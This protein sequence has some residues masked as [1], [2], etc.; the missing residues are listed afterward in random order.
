ML[1]FFVL[2][3][4]LK[5]VDICIR[6]G[7]FFFFIFTSS[8]LC[9]R[10]TVRSKKSKDLYCSYVGLSLMLLCILFT[11]VFMLPN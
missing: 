10:V 6:V 2:L 3:D 5:K 11:Y 7:R 9:L 4:N 1:P 8:C